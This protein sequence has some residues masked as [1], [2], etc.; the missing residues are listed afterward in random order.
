MSSGTCYLCDTPAT[1][2]EHVPP[3]CL[4]PEQKDLEAGLDLR[5]NLITVPSCE[6]HNQ[7]KSGD[8]EYLLYALTMNIVN[9]ETAM[10]QIQRKIVRA[11]TR[12]RSRFDKFSKENRPVFAVDSN[13]NMFN[14]LM[15]RI[16]NERFLKSLRWIAQGLFS[17]NSAISSQESVQS[18]Q[19]SLFF[20]D[21]KKI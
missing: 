12:N 1:S 9:N 19:I 17:T 4:F 8:D 18:C 2:K 7:K 10:T 13:G 5:K 16:D 20:L 14:T 6:T 21:Q 11:I 3:L 15:V